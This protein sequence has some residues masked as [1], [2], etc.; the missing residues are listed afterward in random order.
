MNKE[1]LLRGKTKCC[2]SLMPTG[3]WTGGRAYERIVAWSPPRTRWRRP[4]R[5][6]DAAPGRKCL[7]CNRGG[8]SYIE[9]GRTVYVGTGRR[10]RGYFPTCGDRRSRLHRFCPAYTDWTETDGN[11]RRRNRAKR[12]ASCQTVRR[13]P[14]HIDSR[15]PNPRCANWISVMAL[16]R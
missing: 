13:V 15:Y 16:Y 10:W 2:N 5:R 3:R 12:P 14:R 9:F 8:G 7:R 11:G 6:R 4:C 1:T